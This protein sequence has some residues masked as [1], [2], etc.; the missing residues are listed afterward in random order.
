MGSSLHLGVNMFKRK[1]RKWNVV[2]WVHIE[3]WQNQLNHDF[4][5]RTSL[6]LWWNAAH[7]FSQLTEFH[8]SQKRLS[9]Q[10][11]GLAELWFDV[12]QCTVVTLLNARYNYWFQHLTTRESKGTSQRRCDYPVSDAHSKKCK[13][14]FCESWSFLFQI[15]IS[16]VHNVNDERLLPI[17]ITW[18]TLH[19]AF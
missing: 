3:G 17:L 14:F 12:H 9:N 11:N 7:Q 5:R 6:K 2:K 10:L 8:D 19:C 1:S 16:M 15:G 13:L 4:H 18:C